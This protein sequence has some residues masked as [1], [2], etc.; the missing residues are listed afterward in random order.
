MLQG[1]RLLYV[2]N[3]NSATRLM[4]EAVLS[5]GQGLAAHPDGTPDDGIKLDLMH[6]QNRVFE[7]LTV[8]PGLTNI[9]S[10]PSSS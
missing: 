2:D 7:K 4:K 3:T 5:L 8:T 9:S 10:M 6:C 1:M